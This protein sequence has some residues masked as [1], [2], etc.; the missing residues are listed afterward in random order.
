[1]ISKTENRLV[2]SPRSCGKWSI[3][4]PPRV[5]SCNCST[6]NLGPKRHAPGRA[7]RASHESVVLREGGESAKRTL[8]MCK[9]LACN[10]LEP[11][12]CTEAFLSRPVDGVS[13]TA[14][15]CVPRTLEDAGVELSSSAPRS[16]VN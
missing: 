1:M 14:I 3:C 13:A 8:K 7:K 9:S 12:S 15:I 11:A 10:K 4:L 2:Q 16:A 5:G 6:L